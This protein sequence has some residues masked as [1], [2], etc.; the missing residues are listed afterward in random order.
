MFFPVDRK[1]NGLWDAVFWSA[2]LLPF[3]ALGGVRELADDF[4]HSEELSLSE[5]PQGEFVGEFIGGVT[6]TRHLGKIR[7]SVEGNS[8]TLFIQF[9]AVRQLRNGLELSLNEEGNGMRARGTV[10]TNTDGKVATD[11]SLRFHRQSHS[12]L[13]EWSIRIAKERTTLIRSVTSPDMSALA[14]LRFS[15][16]RPAPR[17]RP[18]SPFPIPDPPPVENLGPLDSAWQGVIAILELAASGVENFY[19]SEASR[20]KM[21]ALIGKLEVVANRS[22]RQSAIADANTPWRTCDQANVLAF[23]APTKWV[24]VCPRGLQ[25]AVNLVQTLVHETAHVFGLKNE[26]DATKIE[27]GM[28]RLANTPLAY[29]NGYM[30]DCN[31]GEFAVP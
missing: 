19:H 30:T 12:Y 8:A 13:I 20:D 18:P 29:T 25:P 27:V 11:F 6:S 22:R 1:S 24:Y 31:L 28:Y 17:V 5:L 4:F 26:C 23:A 21:W 7:L 9:G 15:Q 2:W 10:D 16:R 3:L 14:Y